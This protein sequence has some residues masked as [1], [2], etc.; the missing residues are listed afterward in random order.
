MTGKSNTSSFVRKLIRTLL[1]MV[2]LFVVGFASYLST[3]F[4]YKIT[5]AEHNVK[6][7]SIIKDIVSDTD[8]VD[9]SHNLIYSM[10]ESTGKINH[11]L[12]EV[13]NTKT[14]N[15]DYITIPVNAEFTISNKLYQ[16]LCN[17]K[18]DIPQIV[19][20][21]N[22]SKYFNKDQIYTYGALLMEDLLDVDINYYTV[23]SSSIYDK[24]FTTSKNDTQSEKVQVLSDTFKAKLE[25]MSSK[26]ELKDYI[27]SEYGNVESNL[28]L[29]NKLKYLD[30]YY[31]LDLDNIY[32][33]SLYGEMVEKSFTVDVVKSK[34]LL[35][36]ILGSES[37]TTAQTVTDDS[38]N[39]STTSSVGLKI[40]ILNAS[41]IP[42]LAAKFQDKLTLSGYTV[43]G[44]GN[45]DQGVLT[46]T[47][48][49]VKDESMGSDLLENFNNAEIS[50]GELPEGVDIQIILGTN[51]NILQ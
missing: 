21:K 33:Y 8:V 12:L 5:D 23:I 16:K 51:D 10:N 3:H 44:I 22:L 35:D 26:E 43:T 39:E 36:Q 1:F 18:V 34:A 45:Y 38:S 11:L 7:D 31:A 50:V 48:I 20:V 42:G 30:D 41:E 9:V 6:S 37:H 25:G 14:G 24:Y 17:H 2:F 4:F 46:N 27:S 28:T 19:E 29:K 32:Y 47:R 49:V 13:F 40:Q 15:L